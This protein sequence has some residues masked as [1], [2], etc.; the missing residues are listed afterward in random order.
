M[1]LLSLISFMSLLTMP[2]AASDNEKVY[3]KDTETLPYTIE[4]S[5][6]NE[7]E[8]RAYPEAM[9][10][11]SKG[12]SEAGAFK[13]LFNYISGENT[14]GSEIS[15]TSPV[16]IGNDVNESDGGAGTK[17][18][19]TSPVEMSPTNG[20]MFFLP[21]QYTE[22]NAPVPTH[23]SVSLVKVDARTVAA[24]GYSGFDSEEKRAEHAQKLQQT[25]AENG[26]RVTGNA[27]YLGYD[28]PFTLP[29]N[30]RHEVIMPVA[31]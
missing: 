7:I 2:V 20:M 21:N 11:M 29:W 14:S 13:L 31:K 30:K 25:L 17:I 23:E 22:S 1:R 6:E 5:L 4:A 15:M 12:S 27:S 8:I 18:S 26:Y 16:E 28:S 10:V 24:I 3:Y 9:A 19:M